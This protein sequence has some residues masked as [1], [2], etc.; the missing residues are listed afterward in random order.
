MEQMP[1]TLVLGA[2][3]NPSRYANMAIR[4]LVQHGYPVMA[5][6]LRSGMVGEIPILTNIPEQVDVH[7]V[8]LYVGPQNLDGWLPALLALRPQ[9]I[10]FNP[11][12]ESKHVY[13]QLK[14]AGI[15]VEEV[16]TLV[17]LGMGAYWDS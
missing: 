4:R 11:G 16:C 10:L 1:L 5:V 2:S 3:E 15:A 12:T 8:S 9:R 13:P 17:L 7:T 6:G 14:A